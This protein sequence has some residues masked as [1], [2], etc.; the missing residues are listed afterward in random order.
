VA[1]A[2][3]EKDFQM[4]EDVKTLPGSARQNGYDYVLVP[5]TTDSFAQVAG[6][7]LNAAEQVPVPG[8]PGRFLKGQAA[9]QAGLGA[10]VPPT[11][12][13]AT[14]A[15][16]NLTPPSISG[17]AQVGQVLTRVNGTWSNSPTSFSHQWYAGGV[18]ISGA[19]GA[20]YT[21]V[22]GD[23]GKTITVS[24][25]ATNAIGSSAQVTSAATSAVIAASA[26]LAISG[27][28]GTANVGDTA[29]FTP[30]ISG[31]ASPYNVT[32]TGL[33][34][35]R[36]IN[37]AAT[38]LTTGAYTTAGTYN[39]TYTVTDSSTPQQTASFTRS[40]VVSAAAAVRRAVTGR[41]QIPSAAVT[42]TNSYTDIQA[43]TIYHLLKD[44]TDI[45]IVV[46][47]VFRSVPDAT[48]A[49][50]PTVVGSYGLWDTVTN[51]LIAPFTFSG[52][53]TVT[54]TA[55]QMFESDILT[56]NKPAGTTVEV[57]RL[58]RYATAPA[59]FPASKHAIG[60]GRE[61]NEWGNGL[62]DKTASG[63]LTAARPAGS[64]DPIPLLA[65]KGTSVNNPKV[66]CI[67]GDSITS[68]SAND[69]GLP[70]YLGYAN[71]G[72]TDANIPT[73][74]IGISSQA[75]FGLVATTGSS[76]AN[77]AIFKQLMQMAGVTH[78]FM[79]LGG[80]DWAN[81]RTDVQLDADMATYK[82]ILDPLGIKLI[83]ATL[84]PKTNAANTT[85][86]GTEVNTWTRRAAWNARLISNNGVGYGYYNLAAV[87]QDPANNNI[88]RTDVLQ[89]S[90]V[91][92]ISAGGTGWASSDELEFGTGGTRI[93]V[94]ATGG[95][96]TAVPS[97]RRPGGYLSA[98]FPSG[99]VSPSRM[100]RAGI[101]NAGGTGATF[102]FASAAAPLPV[103]G[104]HPPPAYHGLLAR[105]FAAVAPTLFV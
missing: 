31:G 23:V 90:A 48:L 79:A 105:D 101:Y 36:S 39:A 82:G 62:T 10:S 34:P 24:T 67:S 75:L 5:G 27:A 32:A 59:S 45:S 26:A 38:G 8:Q 83:P 103:D 69:T 100:F 43:N 70:M 71:I 84:P 57:R 88:W 51:T 53:A 13:S 52:A 4:A 60:Q 89:V 20:T 7:V 29:S 37:N 76:P 12:F 19:T 18:A 44:V 56:F 41:T 9:S 85:Y 17:A 40:V 50:L 16:V 42:N 97:V 66:V 49:G 15:P 93:Q 35:G 74:N 3:A 30:T 68:D 78:V 104:I 95:V 64:A 77:M 2:H 14:A 22:A 47:N 86:S 96:V 33:P 25:I 98:N 94:T 87:V 6:T 65:V 46:G 11:T 61:F 102:T 21:P 92:T 81:N 58:H 54:M 28:N 72:L 63:S 73:V 1:K 99:P 80:N 91:P 55:G